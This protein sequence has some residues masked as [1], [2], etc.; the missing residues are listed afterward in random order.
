MLVANRTTSY[1]AYV[2]VFSQLMPGGFKKSAEQ[3]KLNVTCPGLA[4]QII[5]T[6]GAS[7]MF[8]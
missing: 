1:V 8:T 3:F 4:R 7:L 6:A 5:I 2:E